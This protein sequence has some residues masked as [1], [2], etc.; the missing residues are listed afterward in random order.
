MEVIPV[1]YNQEL[2]APQIIEVE[3]SEQPIQMIFR[4][5]TSP[6]FVEQIHQK[7]VPHHEATRSEDEPSHLV[8]EVYK[9]VIQEFREVIQPF[10]K[11]TQEVKPVLEEVRTIV[12]KG[13]DRPQV[14][15]VATPLVKAEQVLV[16][17]KPYW[18]FRNIRSLISFSQS[19]L[20]K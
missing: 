8:H 11:I 4:S 15:A 7:G 9:P 2:A 5:A 18:K 12:A 3:P 6:V 19:C 10:R 14:A 20:K 17:A 16:K 1:Q 13:D